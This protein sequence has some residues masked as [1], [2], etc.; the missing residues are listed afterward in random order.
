MGD[1]F[2]GFG[3]RGHQ[4]FRTTDSDTYIDVGPYKV[5]LTLRF[6][7]AARGC[8]KRINLEIYDTCPDC[9]GSGAKPGSKVVRCGFCNGTGIEQHQTGPFLMQGTCRKCGGSG[10]VITDVCTTCT[11]RGLTKQ[12]KSIA[13]A[14]PYGV[15]DGQTI[16]VAMGQTEIFVK[17]TVLESDVYKRDGYDIWSLAK[18]GVAQAVLGGSPQVQTLH[19]EET[20]EVTPGTSSGDRVK[21]RG[22]GIKKHQ[23]T[24]YGDHVATIEIVTP[25]VLTDHQRDLMVAFGAEEKFSGWANGVTVGSKSKFAKFMEEAKDAFNEEGEFSK[26][27]FTY[28]DDSE[29]PRRKFDKKTRRFHE[30]PEPEP[31]GRNRRRE[32]V[33]ET[34]R[35]KIKEDM[36][37]AQRERDAPYVE[38]EHEKIRQAVEDMKKESISWQDHTIRGNTTPEE[39]EDM[40]NEA[41]EK[42]TAGVFGRWD[43]WKKNTIKKM[44]WQKKDDQ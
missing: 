36:E 25:K 29:A 17:L 7:E 21:F 3:N 42:G 34:R 24:G 11:G 30:E 6:E 28:D 18:I 32:N 9:E 39:R 40:V 2:D 41:K 35:E 15:A 19:G 13:I 8:N 1:F 16:R 37:R 5:D 33:N 10:K 26:T 31:S 43:N 20:F 27:K 12:K 38:P 14:V 23:Q 4:T 22:K 44:P